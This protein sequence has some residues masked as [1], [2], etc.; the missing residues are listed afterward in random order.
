MRVGSYCWA[1]SS[2]VV[3][4]VYGKRS[5][6]GDPCV[7]V[8]VWIHAYVSACVRACVSFLVCLLRD[9]ETQ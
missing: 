9:L 8:C 2:P 4:R 5:V 1:H 6:A 7:L 3:L